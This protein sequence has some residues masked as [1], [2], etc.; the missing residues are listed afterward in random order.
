MKNKTILAVDDSEANRYALVRMLRKAGYGVKEASTGADAL[1]QAADQ[2]DLIILDVNLPDLS[3][4]EVCRQLK[5]DPATAA[6]PVL[7]LSASFVDSDNRAE[8]LEGGAD[9]YLTYPVEPRELVANIEALLRARRAERDLRQSEAQF[10]LMVEGVKDHAIILLDTAGR[11]IAWNDGAQ[12]LLGYTEAEILG[13]SAAVFLTAEDRKAGRHE[14]ELQ[15]AA[16]RCRAGNDLWLARK[17]GSRFWATG[18]TTPLRDEAGKLCGFVQILRDW[19]ERKE[20]EEALRE[21]ARQLAEADRRKDEFL[22]MLAHELR[23]PLAPMR[24]ALHVERLADPNPSAEVQAARDLMERQL[25]QMVRLVDD[26]LDVS[27]ITRGKIQLYKERVDLAAVLARAVESGRPVIEGR[28]HVL[29]VVLPREALPIEADTVRLAQVFLNLLTNAAKYTPEGGRIRLKAAREIS[30]KAGLVAAAPHGVVAVHVQD[31][32]VGIAPE[33]LSRV[34]DLFT[35]VDRSLDR[36][37]GGLG[38]GLTLVRRLTEMH[39]GTVEACSEGIGHG[40]DFAVYLPLAAAAV[41][42]AETGQEAEAAQAGRSPQR[43]FLVVDDNRD[44]AESLAMLLRLLGNDV[45][46]AYD[47]RLALEAATAYR[48]EVVLLDI[49]LPGLNGLEVCQRLRGTPGQHRTVIVAMTGYGRDEDRQRS[50]AAGFD[51][52]LV[53]PVDLEALQELLASPELAARR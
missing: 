17:D 40:S 6:I 42:G 30:L 43:R 1:R 37:A 11:V 8:G 44:S 13:Q 50:R 18:T 53:K 27:R 31:T 21:R 41:T 32:G 3:G 38:I 10:R 48:P 20:L 2:P 34:F 36:A 51:A 24:N 5:A 35:Q 14:R 45:R 4:R 46:T 26:L 15:E 28:H 19:T 12:R 49:G 33:M 22:A 29:E 7:H 52:H 25:E 9:G 47:G 39:G 23:N 16:A